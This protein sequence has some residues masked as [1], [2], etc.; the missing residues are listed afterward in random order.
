MLQ[1]F[2]AQ[3]WQRDVFRLIVFAVFIADVKYVAVSSAMTD[4]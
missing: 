3:Q 2:L 4:P 1:R